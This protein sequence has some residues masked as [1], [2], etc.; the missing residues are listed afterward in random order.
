MYKTYILMRLDEFPNQFKRI[1]TP[2][3]SMAKRYLGRQ[4]E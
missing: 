3:L 2:I 4:M 1:T